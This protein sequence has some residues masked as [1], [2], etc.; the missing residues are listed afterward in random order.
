[1]EAS[2]SEG[3]ESQ[4]GVITFRGE[5]RRHQKK[6]G[7]ASVISKRSMVCGAVKTG[8]GG[9]VRQRGKGAKKGR[10]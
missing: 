9:H 10:T 2:Q 8:D 1:M 5:N 3:R 7:L 6:A 4:V